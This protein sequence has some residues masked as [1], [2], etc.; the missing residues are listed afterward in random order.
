MKIKLITLNIWKQSNL[1][2]KAVDFINKENPDVI[3]L[4]E[5]YNGTDKKLKLQY[6]SLEFF[7]K[8]L[9]LTHS[10]FA[11]T[12]RDITKEDHLDAEQ[13]LTI[14]SRYPIV[15]TDVTFFD[16][17]YRVF[18][19]YEKTPEIFPKI[20]RLLQYVKIKVENN[21]L[22]VFNTHGIW[23]SF[24]LDNERRLKMSEVIVKNIKS[25]ENVILAGD[26]NVRPDTQA[27]RNIE[28]HL[29]NI[30][31]NELRSTF[32]MRR[33]TEPGFATAVVDMVFVSNNM[34]IIDHYCP[35]ADVSDHLPLVCVFEI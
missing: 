9:R 24:G 4:Q 29:K 14:F 10:Q 2:E 26:F 3:C 13:G 17:P 5:V 22:N 25:K 11:P 20:P 6:R 31:K 12:F 8:K 33:K 34:K 23:D 7:K 28:K 30:F 16:L 21:F 15:K 27:I 35:D 19:D 1:Q 18:Y 32:N